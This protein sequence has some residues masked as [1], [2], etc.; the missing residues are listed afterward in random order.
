MKKIQNIYHNIIIMSNKIFRV[1]IPPKFLFDLLDQICFK[2][3]K[4]YLIDINCYK[5]LLFHNLHEPFIESLLFYYHLSKHFYLTRKFTYNSF[6]N[7]IRHIC[8]NA[9]ILYV[10]K[11]NYFK[12]EYHINYLIYYA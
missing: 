10:P 12:S 5:K 4:Y 6:I 11:G 9:N 1:N 7:I 2:T 3:D 8:K